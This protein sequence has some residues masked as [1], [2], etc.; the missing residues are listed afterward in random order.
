MYEDWGKALAIFFWF[1]I[2]VV[3]FAAFG[4]GLFV[5]SLIW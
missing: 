4:I 1:C 2:F 3:F 5:G